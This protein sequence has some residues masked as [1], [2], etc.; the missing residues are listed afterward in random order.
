MSSLINTTV[1]VGFHRKLRHYETPSASRVKGQRCQCMSATITGRVVMQSGKGQRVSRCIGNE[2]AHLTGVGMFYSNLSLCN[3]HMNC[4]CLDY[5]VLGA[6][7]VYK[8]HNNQRPYIR[9]T[10]HSALN[11]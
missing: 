7:R 4:T 3:W 2:C 8:G 6:G 11:L 9:E 10:M 5:R 1:V